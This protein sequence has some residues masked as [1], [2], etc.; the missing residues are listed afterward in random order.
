[1]DSQARFWKG[2]G[3][4]HKKN[5]VKRLPGKDKENSELS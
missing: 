5:W 3:M 1:M 4:S 2:E